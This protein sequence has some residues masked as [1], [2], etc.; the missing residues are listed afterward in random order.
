MRSG[1]DS[2]K[3]RGMAPPERTGQGGGGFPAMIAFTTPGLTEFVAPADGFYSFWVY[4]PGSFGLQTVYSYSTTFYGGSSGALAIKRRVRVSKGQTIKMVVGATANSWS[5]GAI[6]THSTV[7]AGAANIVGGAATDANNVGPG[8][9][10]VASG[11]DVNY[12]GA[13]G[14][15]GIIGNVPAS[16]N[17]GTPG[18]QAS[19]GS[20]GGGGAAGPGDASNSFSAFYGISLKGGN[21]GAGSDAAYG[22]SSPVAGTAPGGGS[23]AGRGDGVQPSAKPG[24]GMIVMMVESS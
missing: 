16:P 22:V 11:G 6:G 24:A 5:A 20:N 4:G 19:G 23:G 15:S 7:S 14:G 17:S 13:L 21:G 8:A 12:P 2:I 3:D 9:A 1:F 18:A 10:G